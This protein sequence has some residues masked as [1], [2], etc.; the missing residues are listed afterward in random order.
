MGVP[1]STQ[2]PPHLPVSP[3]PG[4]R[5]RR[6][7][8][9]R[10]AAP[11]EPARLPEPCTFPRRAAPLQPPSSRRLLLPFLLPS[12]PLQSMHS[13]GLASPAPR[14]AGETLVPASPAP[15]APGG[16]RG[17]PSSPPGVP[18]GLFRPP[19][20]E[21]ADAAA[22]AV[23]A[24]GA[25]ARRPPPLLLRGAEEVGGD[26]ARGTHAGGKEGAAGPRLLRRDL[27]AMPPL[28]GEEVPGGFR[29]PPTPSRSPSSLVPD[30]CLCG[31]GIAALSV[32]PGRGAPLPSLRSVSDSGSPSRP[33]PRFTGGC[34]RRGCSGRGCRRRCR[35]FAPPPTWSIPGSGPWGAGGAGPP[36]ETKRV[37]CVTGGG[38]ATPLPRGS[39][40]APELCTQGEGLD[41]VRA[42]TRVVQTWMVRAWRT[43]AGRAPLKRCGFSPLVVMEEQ[44]RAGCCCPGSP[45]RAG[46]RVPEQSRLSV[47]CLSPRSDSTA[48][49]RGASRSTQGMNQRSFTAQTKSRGAA[50]SCS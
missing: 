19:E 34:G 7:R 28:P 32:S 2:T 45:S 5:P 36:R 24:G 8:A 49:M 14:R 22:G 10:A 26:G 4:L 42:E 16:A 25:L 11:R 37:V 47:S 33:P 23:S 21:A 17:F 44:T 3:S 20:D 1:G 50:S 40:R 39:R 46:R 31:G 9:G 41:P 6:R 38:P 12:P 13:P 15:A 48:E 30:L 29:D 27:G 43:R 35:P 18:A